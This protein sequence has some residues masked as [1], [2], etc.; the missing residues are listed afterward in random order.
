MKIKT[1]GVIGIIF[2]ILFLYSLFTIDSSGISD[3]DLTQ[4]AIGEGAKLA[5]FLIFGVYLIRADLKSKNK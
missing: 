1:K 3:Q 5:F 4:F 2:I